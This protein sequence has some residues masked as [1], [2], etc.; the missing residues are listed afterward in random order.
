MMAMVLIFMKMLTKRQTRWPGTQAGRGYC[1]YHSNE[2][3][4]LLILIIHVPDPPGRG[5]HMLGG[6]CCTQLHTSGRAF[7]RQHPAPAAQGGAR[8]APGSAPHQQQHG[9]VQRSA[10]HPAARGN[11]GLSL[12]PMQTR[13]CRDCADRSKAA[14]VALRRDSGHKARRLRQL[15]QMQVVT[16]AAASR[17]RLQ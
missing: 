2:H 11:A 3:A 5:L 16:G 15:L 7:S 10:A 13:P 1:G 6:T 8:S 17:S 9:P 4:V 12:D 14:A